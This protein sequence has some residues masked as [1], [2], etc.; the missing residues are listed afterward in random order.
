MIT[1]VKFLEKNLTANRLHKNPVDI[2]IRS[3]YHT[4]TKQYKHLLKY[5]KKIFDNKIVESLIKETNAKRV[6]STLKSTSNTNTV[7]EQTI[8]VDNLLDHFKT[9][10]SNIDEN[11][12]TPSQKSIVEQINVYQSNQNNNLNI[13]IKEIEI[14]KAIKNKKKNKKSAGN[15]RIRNEM[16]KCGANWIISPLTKLFNVILKAGIYPDLWTKGLIT[17]IYKSGDKSDPGNYRGICVTSCLG[18]LFY[19]ILNIRLLEFV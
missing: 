11:N 19:S 2:S 14:K 8:P 7:N 4:I 10:H 16:L 15:D 12:H 1:I 6:W 18:K 13:P 17:P 9:L 3:E 5:K